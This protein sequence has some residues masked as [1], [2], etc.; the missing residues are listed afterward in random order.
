MEPSS[1]V[2][3]SYGG[4]LARGKGLVDGRRAGPGSPIR[5]KSEPL[6][7][8]SDTQSPQH[9]PLATALACCVPAASAA[10]ERFAD[11]MLAD[12]GAPFL[13]LPERGARSRPR[14]P[15]AARNLLLEPAPD[16]TGWV[17][18]LDAV[19]VAVRWR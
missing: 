5:F 16:E 17:D 14:A 18:R 12:S 3:T 19:A 2:S 9:P 13:R 11:A 7:H 1:E 10:A 15:A 6:C 8:G 4:A